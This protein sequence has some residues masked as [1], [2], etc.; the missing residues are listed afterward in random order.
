MTDPSSPA[1]RHATM[2]GRYL[3]G[4]ANRLADRHRKETAV[5]AVARGHADQLRA[6]LAQRD[7][8][9]AECQL[10]L[11][12]LQERTGG[13]TADL[14]QRDQRVAEQAEI[15]GQL[16]NRL[17]V[18][19]QALG[20]ISHEALPA[21]IE[22]TYAPALPA[23][24][25]GDA[26]IV[27][28]YDGIAGNIVE[29]RDALRQAQ[30][31]LR[32][33]ERRIAAWEEGMRF[34]IDHQLPALTTGDLVPA[35]PDAGDEAIVG[36]L[37]RIGAAVA[38]LVEQAHDR[39]RDR[40]EALR[41][42]TVGL[43]RNVQAVSHRVQEE[44]TAMVLAHPTTPD[45]LESGYRVDH[46]AAQ[47]ARYAQN[48]AVLCG[49]SPGQQWQEPVAVADIVTAAAS[50]IIAYQRVH[51]SGGPDTAVVAHVAEPLISVIAELLANA[52]QSS[53]STTEVLV[54]IRSV[55]RGV[56]YE[57]DDCGVGMEEFR[58]NRAREIA[59]G[60]LPVRV[61]DLGQ[62]PQTGLAVVG[63]YVRRHGL[64]V[65][66]SES[67][68]GGVRAV[69][70]V[71][72]ELTELLTPATR[73]TRGHH[74]AGSAAVGTPPAPGGVSLPDPAS[75]PPGDPASAAGE[76]RPSKPV[77]PRRRSP[78]HA[79][80][81][82]K[83]PPPVTPS[84]SPPAPP[85]SADEAGSFLAAILSVSPDAASGGDVAD[86]GDSTPPSP[87]LAPAEDTE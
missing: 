38:K 28:R 45:V 48:L 53:P 14:A 26:D 46:A 67:V 44:A 51:A 6:Q 31:A 4:L 25:G 5:V 20:F 65:D 81:T 82:E 3:A 71:P 52:A 59:S 50:R 57:I 72:D 63:E 60:R 56:V 9:L 2:S 86:P 41:T 83:V 21:L 37:D 27:A 64:R 32:I 79:A 13:L 87:P 30:E 35:L 24:L 16:E 62:T 66:L 1:S 58:L 39:F 61:A 55:Q 70:F 7:T 73:L 40:E 29:L 42:A 80:L 75:V 74:R 23:A 54:A 85:P 76:D 47:Q 22:G 33:G 36:V 78:R 12:R 10:Q 49:E 17:E 18:A 77:L 34:V 8:Q 11:G 19:E 15:I 68:Y 43:A 69:V 84:A